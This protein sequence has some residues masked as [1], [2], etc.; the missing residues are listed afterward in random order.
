MTINIS[1]TPEAKTKLRERAATLGQDLS[2]VASD[3]LEE[4]V[5][6]QTAE[7]LLAPARKQVAE[8]GMKDEELDVFFR[9][10]LQEV[11]DKKRAM[12]G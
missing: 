1:L 9:D 5:A 3:L 4:A 6:R 7:E 12:S 8:F 11:R 2:T 10:V